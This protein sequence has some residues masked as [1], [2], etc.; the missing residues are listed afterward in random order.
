[1]H[2]KDVIWASSCLRSPANRVFVQ[3]FVPANI[4][5]LQNCCLVKLIHRWP[6]IPRWGTRFHSMMPSRDNHFSSS[7]VRRPITDIDIYLMSVGL[8][9]ADIRRNNMVNMTSKRR[10]DVSLT[11][12][13]RYYCV[14]CP[15]GVD[16]NFVG[17][18]WNLMFV[19]IP[20]CKQAPSQQQ[21]SCSLS[22]E[23]SVTDRKWTAPWFLCSWWVR[24]LQP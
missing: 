2:Y 21:Q 22:C 1:M 20:W 19:H 7:S 18:L 8:C 15:L 12:L 17:W 24:I 6:G 5:A 3:E 9:P 10:R 14:V 13:W 11:S 16:T 23:Y 4:K